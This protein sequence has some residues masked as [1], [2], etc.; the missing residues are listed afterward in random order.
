MSEI[1]WIIESS[2][3]YHSRSGKYLSSHLLKAFRSSPALYKRLIDSPRDQKDRPAFKVGRAVHCR[4]L[5]GAEEFDRRFK[6]SDGPIN[7]T[8]GQ[9]YGTGTLMY[10]RWAACQTKEV[11]SRRQFDLV[12]NMC[13]MAPSLPLLSDPSGISEAVLRGRYLEDL[14]VSC[15][16]RVDRFN[17]G[18]TPVLIDLKT[19]QDLENFHADVRRFEYVHQVAF[20]RHMIY[21]LSGVFPSI[22]FVAV[23]K[24]EPF[25]IGQFRVSETL[26]ERVEQEN[27]DQ[28]ARLIQCRKTGEWMTG[29]EEMRLIC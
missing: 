12:L 10:K 18:D 29:F 11:L 26:L 25:R 9:P 27:T 4:V 17:A 3:I 1:P 13:R 28:I 15:Q 23:E 6:K 16:I 2:E 24:K 21:E 20:Y 22:V 7:E 5:E 8:T 14:P 19:C